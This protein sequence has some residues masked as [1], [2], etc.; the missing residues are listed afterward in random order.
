MNDALTVINTLKPKLQEYHTRRMRRDFINTYI[1]LN[2]VNIPKHIL[3]SIYSDMTM[4]ATSD[5]NPAMDSRVRHAIISEDADLALDLRHLNK[6]RPG[7]T[8]DQFF[9]L[10]KAKVDEMSAADERRHG[11]E[12]LA[13]YISVKRPYQ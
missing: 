1:N 8:F 3:R 9:D 11:I 6:E 4:D 12:H 7:D 10:L 5:Q 2:D 13:K